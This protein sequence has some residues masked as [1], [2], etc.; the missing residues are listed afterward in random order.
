M[1]IKRQSVLVG[2][3][4][5]L[6]MSACLFRSR[7]PRSEAPN[8]EV[9]YSDARDFLT[10][11]GNAYTTVADTV[12]SVLSK[13]PVS[14]QEKVDHLMGS[15][16]VFSLRETAKKIAELNLKYFAAGHR[17]RL[18][19]DEHLALTSAAEGIVKDAD[20]LVRDAKNQPV[21]PPSTKRSLEDAALRVRRAY[22]LIKN[23][24]HL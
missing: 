6:L 13:P 19:A 24:P 9:P 20:D 17:V 4:G 8:L 21:M 2:L 23:G 5:T 12:Q 7:A 3:L 11:A 22:D 18:T 1:S 15:W 14:E 10:D 16:V